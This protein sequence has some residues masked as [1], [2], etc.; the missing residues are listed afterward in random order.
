MTKQ[1][2]ILILDGKK[3]MT[4]GKQQMQKKI[5]STRDVHDQLTI[6]FSN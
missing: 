6:K 5:K 3:K 2:S 1:V 4:N